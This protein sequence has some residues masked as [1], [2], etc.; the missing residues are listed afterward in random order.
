MPID[1]PS[2]CDRFRVRPECPYLPLQAS[3]VEA[4]LATL[5]VFRGGEH[6][7]YMLFSLPWRSQRPLVLIVRDQW[8]SVEDALQGRGNVEE[9]VLLPALRCWHTAIGGVGHVGV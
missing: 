1:M 2:V 7:Q 9:A 4:W 3:W 8:V 5:R 6:M